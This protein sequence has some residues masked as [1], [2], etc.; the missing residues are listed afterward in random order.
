[1]KVL[2]LK[3]VYNLGRAGEIKKVASGFGRNFLLP[4]KLA[5]LA[6]QGAQKQIETIKA[7]ASKQRQVLNEELGGLAEQLKSMEIKFI[8]KV[9]ETGKLFG[10]ITPAMIAESISEKLGSELDRHLIET[11]PLRET[12]EYDVRIRLT[13]DLIPTVK[14]IVEAEEKEEDKRLESRGKRRPSSAESEKPS[15]PAEAEKPVIVVESAPEEKVADIVDAV[16][17]AAEEK[18]ADSVDAVE[19]EEPAGE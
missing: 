13:F 8:A 14:V 10:S 12:G 1:M 2:L 7:S 19:P 15:V 6:T 9:G 3:D 4:Q 11:Q 17:P 16:E 18:A 5:V